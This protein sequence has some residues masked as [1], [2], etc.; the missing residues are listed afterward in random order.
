MVFSVSMKI[1]GI[2]LLTYLIFVYSPLKLD[3]RPNPYNVSLPEEFKGPL[4]ENSYLSHAEHLFEGQIVKPESLAV[5]DGIIYT[6]VSDGRIIK[7]ENDKISTLAQIGQK[8]EGIWEQH[9]CGRVLGMKFDKKNQLHVVDA[10]YGLYVVD[11]KSGKTTP[12]LNS[13]TL[14]DGKPLVFIN[15]VAIDDKGIIYITESSNRWPLSKVLY[16]VLE[17]E[18]SGRVIRFDPNSNEATVLLND[19]NFPNGIILS[20][21]NKS[22]L[23]AET[24]NHRILKYNLNE[25][26][27]QKLEIFMDGLP[28]EPD[29]LSYGTRQSYWIGLSSGRNASN[30][31]LM[32]LTSQYPILKKIFIQLLNLTGFIFRTI[33]QFLYSE[34]FK[35]FAFEIETGH[36][37]LPMIPSYGMI[38]ESDDK[39]QVIKSLHSP[40]G[41]MTYVSEVLEYEN[42][43]Y[44]GSWRNNFLGKLKL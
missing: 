10:Y 38:I 27:P 7:I 35:T 5:L 16:V 18:N 23:I 36:I 11:I 25:N 28:G 31:N 2:C 22:I 13:S 9:K 32:D 20:H 26:S 37:F 6:G 34:K 1:L 8:C 43:L 19:L 15:D 39:G 40:D 4:S 44:L 24:N 41:K 12:I 29:N 21:D 3:F 14:I 30:R 17:H 42:H 33:S